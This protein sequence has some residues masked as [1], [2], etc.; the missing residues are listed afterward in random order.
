MRLFPMFSD[1]RDRNVLVVGGGAVAWRKAALLMEAQA[2]VHV[3]A[4]VLCEP[5]G[6][7][8]GRGAVR[9]LR[10]RYRD[11][12]L[13]GQC[14]VVAATGRHS[15][16]AEV[17]RDAA[18]RNLWVNVVDDPDL[19]SFHVPAIVDRSP[20]MVAVSS[21]G[22]A[23]V[24]ARRLR[25][26]IESLLDPALAGLAELA[27]QYR[28]RIR[29]RYPDM[30]ERR[31][32]YDWMFDGPVASRLT[33]G[34]W[35][36]TFAG[37]LEDARRCLEDGLRD[38][39][40]AQGAVCFV[41]V[42]PGDPDLLTLRGLRELGAADMVLHGHLPDP[43]VLGLARR[44]ADCMVV[45]AA[46]PAVNATPLREALER[47]RDGARAAYLFSGRRGAPRAL[48]EALR[49][50]GYCCRWIPGAYDPPAEAPWG[51]TGPRPA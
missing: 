28:S 10:G 13:D 43:A 4:P 15:V 21:T 35:S 48:L 45:E 23:P 30:D 51:P 14:L 42:G 39:P 11:Q 18:R 40:R 5:L 33:G 8:A 7:L 29:A 3:G 12:W 44:D 41:D 31:R 27:R 20:L 34:G 37:G 38:G 49:E 6:A 22:A 47:V 24:L 36:G 32:F 19:S 17:A 25:G 50:H 16:N 9:H 46:A 2:C 1:V 26:R